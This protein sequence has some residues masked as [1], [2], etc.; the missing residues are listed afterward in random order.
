VRREVGDHELGVEDVLV[1]DLLELERPE[2]GFQRLAP[3]DLVRHPRVLAPVGL[4][5]LVDRVDP[6]DGRAR[7]VPQDRQAAAR[8]QHARD[9][10]R[11]ALEIEPVEGLGDE[12]G[13]DRCVGQGDRLRGAAQHLRRR[14]AA[15]QD[16]AHAVDRLDRDHLVGVLDQHAGQLPGPGGEIEDR[17]GAEALDQARNCARRPARPRAI[18]VLR[19]RAERARRHLVDA[20]H[21]RPRALRIRSSRS[22]YSR[23][24]LSGS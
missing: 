9:L 23:S 16:R 4:E 20:H 8:A 21:S 18:V 19:L 10:S 22:L 14:H 5:R 13:V 6:L 11:R 7:P 2:H 24:T 17:V 1:V 3:R 15:L 12:D